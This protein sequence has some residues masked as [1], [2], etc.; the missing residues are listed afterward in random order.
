MNNSVTMNPEYRR[1]PALLRS[2]GVSRDMGA[3]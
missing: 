1:S 2:L 3:L